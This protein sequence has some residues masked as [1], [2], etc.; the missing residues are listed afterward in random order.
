[1]NYSDDRAFDIFLGV[2]G[3][4]MLALLVLML[5]QVNPLRVNARCH[6]VNGWHRVCY[7]LRTGER[8]L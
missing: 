5:W 4:A 7:S 6:M 2:A 1:M 3:A 8:V